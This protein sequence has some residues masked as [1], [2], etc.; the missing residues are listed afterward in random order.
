[1]GPWRAVQSVRKRVGWWVE[2][3]VFLTVERRGQMKD[4]YWAESTVDM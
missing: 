4:D 3:M 2:T 1:M